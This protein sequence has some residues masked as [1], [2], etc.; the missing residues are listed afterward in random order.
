MRRGDGWPILRS[1]AIRWWNA[2]PLNHV[3][4]WR[5]GKKKVP[6]A[7]V[8]AMDVVRRKFLAAR[9]S[10]PMGLDRGAGLVGKLPEGGAES[11]SD[12][13]SAGG[14]KYPDR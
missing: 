4:S 2:G 7:G 6:G 14:Q 10:A 1:R 13:G 8:G 5:E 12:A 11:A 9:A 3:S